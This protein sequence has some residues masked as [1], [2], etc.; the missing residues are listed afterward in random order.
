MPGPPPLP[1]WRCVSQ[2]WR[3]G[4][5]LPTAGRSDLPPLPA[6][7][8][9]QRPT[10]A[11]HWAVGS[12]KRGAG[13]R[14]AS[15]EEGGHPDQAHLDFLAQPGLVARL[16][17]RSG[18]RGVAHIAQG[19]TASAWWRGACEAWC[20]VAWGGTAGRNSRKAR[21]RPRQLLRHR[22]PP[23]AALLQQAGLAPAHV[24]RLLG[25]CRHGPGKGG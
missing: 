16:L 20:G 5:W 2:C 22:S 24:L 1:G 3:A 8:P 25:C 15:P 17:R 13:Q 19:C 6:L 12:A 9:G 21:E 11:P 23:L 7:S 10:H 14:G 18:A 4:R